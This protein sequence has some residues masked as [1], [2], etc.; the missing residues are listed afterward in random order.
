MCTEAEDTGAG[1]RNVSSLVL[2][3]SQGK[4]LR[5][6]QEH[7]QK[8]L[9]CNP[10]TSLMPGSRMSPLQLLPVTVRKG[11]PLKQLCAEI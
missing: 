11:S 2:G 5:W 7:S 8:L 1:R 6:T 4:R 10:H 9:R 3:S